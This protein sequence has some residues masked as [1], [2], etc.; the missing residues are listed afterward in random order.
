MRRLNEWAAAWEA[1]DFPRYLSF[2]APGFKPSLGN[3]DDWKARRRAMLGKPG[4]VGVKLEGVQTVLISPERVETRFTQIYT[5]SDYQ[6][7][8]QKQLT[9]QL[10][11]GVWLI[12]KESSR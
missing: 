4:Q 2:Y 7:V 5:S 12:V 10:I 6:D 1:K 11:G 9:W 8:T 3:I